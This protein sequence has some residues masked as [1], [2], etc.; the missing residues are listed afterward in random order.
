M[1]ADQI[2]NLVVAV[3]TGLAACIPL[4]VKLV[5]Y[6]QKAT[7]EKNWST[8]L[9]LVVDLMEEAEEKFTDGATRKEWVM[10]MVQ[11]SAEYIN[12]PVDTQALSDMIDALC[13]M[14][15]IVN[16]PAVEELAD[17]STTDA[18]TEGGAGHD[19]DRAAE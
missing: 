2:V 14:T 11:T 8:L 16:P 3:L 12:Y 7:Q 19:G 10:A 13:D 9:G 4:A 1:S 6:V 15:K 18:E 17:G 5:Q